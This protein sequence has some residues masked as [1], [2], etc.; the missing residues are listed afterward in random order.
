M[1]RQ[2]NLRLNV[3]SFQLRGFV[4]TLGSN[5]K[6]VSPCILHVAAARIEVPSIVSM[7]CIGAQLLGSRNSNSA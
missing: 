5:K 3:T 6:G 1:A 7:S 4:P 2:I